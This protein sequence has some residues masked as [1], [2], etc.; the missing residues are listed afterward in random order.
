MKTLETLK[1]L[2]R[3]GN[4][5]EISICPARTRAVQ[6]VPAVREQVAAQRAVH[7]GAQRRGLAI[8]GPAGHRGPCATDAMPK[9]VQHVSIDLIDRCICR[10]TRKPSL[11]WW[12]ALVKAHFPRCPRSSSYKWTAFD[13]RPSDLLFNTMLHLPR[14]VPRVVPM[15]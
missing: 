10:R 1:T 12:V 4:E 8:H 9:A 5:K 6:G 2:E 7:R 14:L 13:R 3:D 11:I 15:N